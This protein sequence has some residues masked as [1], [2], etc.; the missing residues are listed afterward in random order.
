MPYLSDRQRVE[1]SLPPQVMLGVVIAGVDREDADYRRALDLLKV[2][3]REPIDD[4]PEDR[5]HKILERVRRVHK[6]VLGPYSGEGQD[7]AKFGLVAFYWIKAMVETGYFVFAEGSAIDEAMTLFIGAI[8][9]R[10]QVPAIDASAQKQARKL[11]RSLQAL[12]YYRG[13]DLLAVGG[14]PTNNQDRAA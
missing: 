10:A 3:A 11:I 7:V 14:A 1:I 8:E 4:L 12:G 6:E 5:A 13:L 9:H 2:A